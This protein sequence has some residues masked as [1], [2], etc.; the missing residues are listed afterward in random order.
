MAQ[1]KQSIDG[2]A[3]LAVLLEARQKGDV[4][5]AGRAERELARI[6]VKVKL[7]D[8]AGQVGDA[9]QDTEADNG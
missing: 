1:A 3:W 7:S 8:R 4:D 9:G 6:G 2:A 5:A